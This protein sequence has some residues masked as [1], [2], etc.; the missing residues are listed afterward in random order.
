MVESFMRQKWPVIALGAATLFVGVLPPVLPAYV[1]MLITQS[2][3][4]GIVAMSLDILVGYLGLA[5]LGH[6]AY[7][8]IG[9]YTTAILL[10]KAGWTFW[11][12]LVASLGMAMAIAA[13]VGLLALRAVGVYFLLITLAIAM[14]FWGLIHSWV[15]LTGAENGIAEIPRPLNIGPFDF[16]DPLLFHY[17]ILLVFLTVFGLLFFFIRSPFGKTLV[18]IRDNETRMRVLGYNTWLHKYTAFILAGAIAG[19]AGSFF[20]TFNKFIGPD[21]CS[22]TQCMDILLMVSI[23]GQGT[24]VGANIGAFLVTFLKNMLSVY[25]ERW[26]MIMALVYILCAKYAPMGI[27]GLWKRLQQRGKS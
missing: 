10:T 13:L 21:E 4:Y 5:S 12:S 1:V 23:G 22:L 6:A 16:A 27:I 19:I 24:L 26:L 15:S 8:A 2:M 11:P 25:T 7:F 17:F 18:A 3:I 9:G 14:S 20:A